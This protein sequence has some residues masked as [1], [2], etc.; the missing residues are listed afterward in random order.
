MVYRIR[1]NGALDQTWSAWLG[2]A[3]ICT[4]PAG[5]EGVITTL[6]VNLRDQAALFGILDRIRDLNLKLISVNE[7]GEGENSSFHLGALE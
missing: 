1:I 6:T 3:D 2:N 4:E 7:W 5:N